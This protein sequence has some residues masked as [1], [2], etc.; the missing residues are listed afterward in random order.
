MKTHTNLSESQDSRLLAYGLEVKEL[1]SMTNTE[2][3]T[4]ELW[5]MFSGYMLAQNELGYS[6]SISKTFFTFR[7]L[8]LFFEKVEI[9]RNEK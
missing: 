5:T 7:D 8:L 4:N 9:I 6:P 3:W 2:T 1:L